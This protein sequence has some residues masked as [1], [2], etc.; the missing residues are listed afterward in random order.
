MT[1]DP[2]AKDIDHLLDELGDALQARAPAGYVFLLVL[3]EAR[4]DGDV[5]WTTTTDAAGA[6]DLARH[7]VDDHPPT[8][9]T[10]DAQNPDT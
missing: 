5:A 10:E 1:D 9:E 3:A 8:E 7:V 2:R 4:A 6:A